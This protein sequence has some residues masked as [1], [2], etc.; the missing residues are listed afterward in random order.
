MIKNKYHLLLLLAFFS[1]AL[2]L[3]HF[4]KAEEKEAAETHI[5]NQFRAIQ[6]QYFQ[7]VNLSAPREQVKTIP[8]F[9]LKL[10]NIADL[11]RKALVLNPHMSE[12]EKQWA[13]LIYIYDALLMIDCYEAVTW[14]KL[15]MADLVKVRRFAK[16]GASEKEE[17]KARMSYALSELVAAKQLRPEDKRINGWLE[18]AKSNIETIE[19]GKISKQT[20]AAILDMV[21][22]RPTFNL[23]TALIILHNEQASKLGALAEEAKNFVDISEKK[24]PCKAFPQ[25]CN[26]GPLAPYNFQGAIVELGDIFLR[27]AEYY[28]E[29]GDLVNAM[30]MTQYAKGTYEQLDL[31]AHAEQTKK[32]PAKDILALRKARLA[33]IEK[34]QIPKTAL[35][36]QEAYQRAYACGTC[37]SK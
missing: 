34:R 28:L 21:P 10:N 31:P 24:D 33:Q 5:I 4:S 19:T 27:R 9:S 26:N 2:L 23:W 32:W 30:M 1:F 14:K 6:S 37:H 8:A 35:V 12:S 3:S 20:Q 16:P 29:K 15:T 7:E 22:L 13:G 25:D 36:K 17:L 18:G 11:Q